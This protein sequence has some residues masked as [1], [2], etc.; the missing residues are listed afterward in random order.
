MDLS[1]LYSGQYHE[2][3]P[4]QYHEL[5]PG[6]YHEVTEATKESLNHFHIMLKVNPG[7]YNEDPESK[8]KNYEDSYSDDYKV[9]LALCH[10]IQ[11]IICASG[12]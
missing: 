12:E 9:T 10:L 8:Y 11:I 3:N 2:V 7:T 5:N 1:L 4:G 6:Q